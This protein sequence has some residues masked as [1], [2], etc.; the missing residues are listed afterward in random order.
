MA[1]RRLSVVYS[2]VYSTFGN[3]M[4]NRQLSV[5]YSVVYSTMRPYIANRPLLLSVSSTLVIVMSIIFKFPLVGSYIGDR[6][7]F[8][9]LTLCAN[10]TC[11]LYL[12]IVS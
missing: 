5:V 2:D 9:T 12:I 4:A 1:N 8:L 6:I 11:T 3:C 7:E 10:C